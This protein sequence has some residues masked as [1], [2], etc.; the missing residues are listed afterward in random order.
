M[1]QRP[2]ERGHQTRQEKREEFPKMQTPDKLSDEL[3]SVRTPGGPEKCRPASA[4]L[5]R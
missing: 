1:E 5:S 2:S 3:N 4:N